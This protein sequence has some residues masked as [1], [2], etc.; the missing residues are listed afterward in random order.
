LCFANFEALASVACHTGVLTM[1]LMIVGEAKLSVNLTGWTQLISGPFGD[2]FGPRH[3]VET[4]PRCLVTPH[5][6]QQ[7]SKYYN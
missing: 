5:A 4:L 3:I 6:L 1:E 7:I 2:F